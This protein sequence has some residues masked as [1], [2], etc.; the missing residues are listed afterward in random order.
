VA[1]GNYQ[2]ALDSFAKVT[3]GGPATARIVRLWTYYVKS[4]MPQ[5]NTASAQPAQAPAP[6]QQ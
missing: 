5:T 4:K 2:D 1:L 3:G 6:A